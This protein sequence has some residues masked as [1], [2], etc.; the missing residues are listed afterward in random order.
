[1]KAFVDV[2]K[3]IDM[4]DTVN[5]PCVAGRS[6]TSLIMSDYTIKWEVVENMADLAVYSFPGEFFDSLSEKVVASAS[7][8]VSEV[9]LLLEQAINGQLQSRRLFGIDD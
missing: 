8:S 1:M 2:V 7:S 9:R 3:G 4:F 5:I 6:F